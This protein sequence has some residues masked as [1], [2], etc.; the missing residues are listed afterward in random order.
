MLSLSSLKKI[1]VL[2]I[3]T[4][5]LNL[6]AQNVNIV[7]APVDHLFVP[8][9]FDNNDNVEVVVTGKFPNPCYSM[10]KVD[11]KVIE[12]SIKINITSIAKKFQALRT[13]DALKIPFSEKVTIGS[14]QA[15]NYKV[16]VNENS[17][18][19]LKD[20]INIAVSSSNS[21]DENIY[22]QIDYVDLGFTGGLSGDVT[23]VG[24]NVSSCL[25]FEKVEFIHNNKDTVSIMPIMK[26]DSGDCPE[27]RSR[28]EIPV[29][30]KPE[31]IENKKVLLFVRSMEGKSIQSFIEK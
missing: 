26:K 12:D 15:G 31:F 19:E 28:L 9:G 5:S 10:N 17:S 8:A 22:A 7:T 3:T 27:V 24:S 1:S 13:C 11:V 16:I 4:L 23:L 6:M 30:I 21:V 29:K 2:S 20:Q 14:L 18:H 25:H